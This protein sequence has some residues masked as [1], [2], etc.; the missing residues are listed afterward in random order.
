MQT[1]TIERNFQSWRDAARSQ[2]QL[3]TS[4][5]DVFWDD[6]TAEGG[7][8]PAMETVPILVGEPREVRLPRDFVD[9]AKW[10]AC[11]VDQDR[12]S[13]LYR[14]AWRIAINDERHLL[15]L[16]TDNDVRRVYAMAKE[17]RRDRHKM[18]AFVRFRKTGINPEN[19]REQFV[20][21]FEPDNFIVELT[22]PFFKNRFTSM[23]WSILTPDC[24]AHWDGKNLSFTPGI[25]KHEAPQTEDALDNYWRSYYSHI[26][27]PARLKLNAMRAEMPVKYWKNL[28]EASLIAELTKKASLRMTDMIDAGVNESRAHVR[29][30]IPAGVPIFE[31]HEN[32]DPI[33]VLAQADSLSLKEIVDFGST[34][35]ACGIC[36]NATQPVFGE[37]PEDA[38]I[39][40]IG[41]QPGDM[42]DITG[43]PFIGPAGK[44]LDD[45]LEL[46]GLNRSKIYVTNSVKGFKWKS[47]QQGRKRRLHDTANRGEVTK[48]KPWLLTELLKVQ[49]R[50]IILLGATAS[51]ALLGNEFKITDQRGVLSNSPIAEKVVATIHPSSLLRIQDESAKQ[52]ETGRFISDLKLAKD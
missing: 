11:H 49:P 3:A 8:F 13:L 42:E 34:C 27:N 25:S 12:W 33:E 35:Q 46:A 40:I 47:T 9:L 15:N 44:L 26:F 38:D 5:D 18:T 28:P 22:A 21:W 4:P 2:L 52:I 41:E 7:L 6:G 31:T 43:R 39:M 17:I 29:E 36:E 50:K 45:A 32:R 16:E 37:G 48:C 51:K 10:V 14:I 23:D 30:K 19:D 1:I 20:A 24:C